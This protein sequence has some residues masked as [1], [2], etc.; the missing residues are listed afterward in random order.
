MIFQIKLF[1]YSADIIRQLIKDEYVDAILALK[2]AAKIS[3]FNYYAQAPSLKDFR[4]L[5]IY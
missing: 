5:D 1:D 2:Y 3:H 4:S